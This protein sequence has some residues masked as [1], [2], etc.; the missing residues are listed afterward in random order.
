MVDRGYRGVAALGRLNWL[1]DG[2]RVPRQ[3][4]GP[5]RRCPYRLYLSRRHRRSGP[6]PVHQ[7]AGGITPRLSGSM[8]RALK[9]SL[10]TAIFQGDRDHEDNQSNRRYPAANLRFDLNSRVDGRGLLP[11]S[12]LHQPEPDGQPICLPCH[13][14]GSGD[15][16][17]RP[18]RR[19]QT[20][21]RS[22]R[23]DP[24]GRV[25]FGP[26]GTPVI[27]NERSDVKNP[28]GRYLPATAWGILRPAV[29]E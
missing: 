18:D 9:G 2:G 23:S 26:P 17:A 6:V 15:V 27:L 20:G 25:R 24:T 29:S 4:W 12:R 14:H 1:C 8:F 16:S 13:L 3:D 19:G 5:Q 22:G 7:G 11:I 28:Q 10:Q 21:R